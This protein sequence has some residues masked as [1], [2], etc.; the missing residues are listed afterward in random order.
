MASGAAVSVDPYLLG[1]STTPAPPEVGA[2]LALTLAEAGDGP[3]RFKLGALDGEWAEFF[4]RRLAVHKAADEGAQTAW[5]AY[6][7]TMDRTRVRAA[8]DL[9]PDSAALRDDCRD[10]ARSI[11][12]T[13]GPDERQ[14]VINVL[15]KH[16]R[17]ARAEGRAAAAV[18]QKHGVTAPL[19]EATPDPPDDWTIQFDQAWDA[20]AGTDASGSFLDEA[21]GWV[22]R[23]VE[24]SA[25]DLGAAMS[26][27]IRGG[28]DYQD[29]LDTVDLFT[30]ADSDA[31][32]YFTDLAVSQSL[33]EGAVSL[34]SAEGIV[35]VEFMT[36][37]DSRVCSACLDAEGGNPWD[38]SE[39]PRPGLHGGCRCAIA[40]APPTLL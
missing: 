37:G 33:S 1:W 32:K 29:L 35:K 26:R 27:T 24:G 7:A 34:Y 14:A 5:R 36:A 10:V 20:L 30:E 3:A 12:A 22:G 18:L 21:T 17:D 28:G 25:G 13:G 9:E 15:A 8:V 19:Q 40:A 4:R 16:L 6:A 2:R 39:I 38:V 31:V 11:L 23:F